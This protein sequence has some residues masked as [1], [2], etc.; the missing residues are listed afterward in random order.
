MP[1]RA[2]PLKL[3]L[4]T[5]QHE[6]REQA[7]DLRQ[8]SQDSYDRD[9]LQQAA[10]LQIALN[11]HFLLLLRG[12]RDDGGLHLVDSPEPHANAS[13][14]GQQGQDDR[15]AAAP[16]SRPESRKNVPW[17]GDAST[18]SNDVHAPACIREPFRDRP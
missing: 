13:S 16:R 9:R 15:R 11:A 6:L 8:Q 14:Y 7:E 1:G 10:G 12:Q 2:A 17:Q 5:P 18:D 4:I 3:P